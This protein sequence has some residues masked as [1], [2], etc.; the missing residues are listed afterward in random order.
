MWLSDVDEI[1][2]SDIDVASFAAPIDWC[3]APKL[4]YFAYHLLCPLPEAATQGRPWRRAL[5]CRAGALRDY[6]AS[7]PTTYMRAHV[8]R[9]LRWN[10]DRRGRGDY[11]TVATRAPYTL[12][13]RPEAGPH[14]AHSH[15]PCA[16]H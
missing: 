7:A 5:L 16:F 3:S 15:T 1:M 4:R 13:P 11:M 10:S 2:D 6:Y 9:S 8:L 12:R 14:L